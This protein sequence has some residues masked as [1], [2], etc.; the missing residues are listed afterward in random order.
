MW[1]FVLN[2]LEFRLQVEA[3]EEGRQLGIEQGKQLGIKPG[4]EQGKLEGIQ[5]A[6]VEFVRTLLQRPGN[7]QY[8]AQ[9]L[10]ELTG[11]PLDLI[12][13]QLRLSSLQPRNTD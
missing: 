3:R 11:A 10:H 4:I 6:Q 5:K 13:K 1:F 7:R 9:E 12:E 2:Y 8:S